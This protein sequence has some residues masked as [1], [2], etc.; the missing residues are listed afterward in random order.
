[1]E[2]KRPHELTARIDI[3]EDEAVA[4]WTPN[5]IVVIQYRMQVNSVGVE[6]M[7]TGVAVQAKNTVNG[8]ISYDLMSASK[9]LQ[10]ITIL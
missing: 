10:Q 3:M 6:E 5:G 9:T 8:R 1:M 4:V 7:V 2:I